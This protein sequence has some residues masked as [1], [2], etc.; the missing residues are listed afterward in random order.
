MP[1]FICRRWRVASKRR[2]RFSRAV[3]AWLQVLRGGVQL[4]GIALEAGDG[5][6]ISEEASLSVRAA[7]PAEVMLFDLP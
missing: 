4:N 2:T 3:L 6:A 7:G 5:A 1:R